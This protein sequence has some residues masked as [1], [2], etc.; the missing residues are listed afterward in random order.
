VGAAIVAGLDDDQGWIGVSMAL[1]DRLS[2]AEPISF[3]RVSLRGDRW[4]LPGVAGG[5]HDNEVPADALYPE[6]TGRIS[7]MGR[8]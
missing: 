7:V 8:L 3:P 6:V 4:R 5:E 1:L 2:H